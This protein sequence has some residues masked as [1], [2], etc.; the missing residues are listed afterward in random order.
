[1]YLP[2]LVSIIIPCFNAS[3]WLSEAIDSCL[4]QTYSNI[5]II[6]IDD[7]STDNS[8]EII[9]N[10]SDKYTNKIKYRSISH[11][12]G[13]HARNLAISLSNGEYIQFLD[14]DDYILP[15]KIERQVQFLETTDADVVYG[16]WRYQYHRD[17]GT[18]QLGKIE[19][20]GIQSDILESLLATWW[21]AVAALLYKRSSVDNSDGW[22]ENLP[23]VQDRDFFLSVVINGAKVKYQSGCYSIYRRY[24]DVTVSTC[25]KPRWIACHCLVLEKTESKLL[26]LQR[27]SNNYRRAMAACYFDL[28]RTALFIDYSLYLKLVDAALNRFPNFE[29]NSTKRFYHLVRTIIGFRRT[30]RIICLILITKNIFR[31]V[32]NLFINQFGYL[33]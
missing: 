26:D 7:G 24:G 21:V 5:E 11:S 22:D 33:V 32:L 14:A 1:M 19:I 28:A 3:R 18:I 12:G 20:S 27:L 4:Q 29:G 23:A 17:N 10:Y 8:W 13:N 2:K 25:S 6:I 30:E 15:E 16:D 31:S 9:K